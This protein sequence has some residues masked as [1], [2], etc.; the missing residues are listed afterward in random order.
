M[1]EPHLSLLATGRANGKTFKAIQWVLEGHEVSGYPGWSRVMIVPNLQQFEHI[2]KDWWEKIEDFDH[3]IYTAEDWRNAHNVQGSTEVCL[4][5][6]EWFL[7][8]MPGNLT[9]LTMTA[10]E[11]EPRTEHEHG[12]EMDLSMTVGEALAAGLV[13]RTFPKFTCG[14]WSPETKVLC[15]LEPGHEGAHYAKTS[16]C[17]TVGWA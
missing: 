15:N 10:K 16:Y 7:P 12:H 13:Y 2:R 11:W 4:D 14:S 17:A 3:R 8:G 9:H 6:A 1:P 5:N